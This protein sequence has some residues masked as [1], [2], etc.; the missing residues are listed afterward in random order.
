MQFLVKLIEVTDTKDQHAR[1]CLYECCCHVAKD[2]WLF[3]GDEDALDEGIEFKVI[4][5][6]AIEG[7][8]DMSG[9]EI[10]KMVCDVYSIDRC[11]IY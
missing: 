8:G 5:E 11:F 1:D 4:G 3:E 7:Y 6:E 10:K 2:F 9:R